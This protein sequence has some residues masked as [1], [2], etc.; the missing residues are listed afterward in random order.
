MDWTQFLLPLG[1]GLLIGIICGVLY[2]KHKKAML[3]RIAARNAAL[4]DFS[5]C[6]PH[7]C[8]SCAHACPS[9]LQ[10]KEDDICGQS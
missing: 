10:P 5:T 3:E 9:K 1:L 7:A 4:A 8:A 6:N 2:R